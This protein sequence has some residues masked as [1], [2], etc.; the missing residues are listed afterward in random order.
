MNCATPQL[1]TVRHKR[2]ADTVPTSEE[3]RVGEWTGDARQRL[4]AQ[5]T[6][7]GWGFFGNVS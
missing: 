5:Q 2:T 6:S 7:C 4:S 1:V 3:N